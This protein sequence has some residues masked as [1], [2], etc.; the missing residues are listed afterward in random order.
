M[1]KYRIEVIVPEGLVAGDTFQVEVDIEKKTGN[2]GQRR[3]TLTGIPLEEMTLD[4]LKRAKINANSVLYKSR[5][6]GA[7]D[8]TIAAN[9][10]RYDAVCKLLEEKTPAKTPPVLASTLLASTPVESVYDDDTAGEI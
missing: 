7:S 5:Q 1:A 4:Q 3:G 6:R 8:E 9:Q 2:K 10:E